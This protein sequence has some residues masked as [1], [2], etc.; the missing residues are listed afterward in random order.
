M[1]SPFG[2]MAKQNGCDVTGDAEMM[3]VCV[4]RAVCCLSMWVGYDDDDADE[5]NQRLRMRSIECGSKIRIVCVRR[6]W[7]RE[8][9]NV[10][11]V[12]VVCWL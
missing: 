3:Q 1:I 11:T 9:D 2:L 10:E 4:D 7:S 12:M 6:R 8:R 5:G